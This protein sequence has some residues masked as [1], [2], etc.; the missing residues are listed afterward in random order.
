MNRGYGLIEKEYI[1]GWKRYLKGLK[2]LSPSSL[3][4]G[5]LYW[6]SAMVLKTHQDKTHHGVTASLSVPWGEARGD[7]EAGGYHLIWPRDLVKSAFAFMAIE[8]KEAPV[9]ILKFLALRVYARAIIKYF[10]INRNN[11]Q[12]CYCQIRL[13]N[14]INSAVFY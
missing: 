6:I 11:I 14:K 4:N 2:D 5:R 9:R 3:D 13:W 10:Y 7:G 8:D 1:N 12:V